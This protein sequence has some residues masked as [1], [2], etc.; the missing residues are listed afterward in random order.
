MADPSELWEWVDA[1]GVAFAFTEA[2]GLIAGQGSNFWMPQTRRTEARIPGRV[3]SYVLDRTYRE[4]TAA[5]SVVVKSSSA[6]TMEAALAAWSSR[7]N[8]LRGAGYLRHT[9][10]DGITKRLLYCEYDDGLGVQQGQGIWRKGVQQA[11]LQF[12]A[13]DPFWYDESLTTVTFTSGTA[14]AAFFPIPNATTGSFI[15]LTASEVFASTTVDNEGD[16]PVFPVWTIAGPASSIALRNT[17][18]GKSIAFSGLSLTAGQTLT[19]DT[20]PGSTE[21]TVGGSSVASYLTDASE[22]WPLELGD[23]VVSVELAGTLAGT[24][25]ASLSYRLPHLTP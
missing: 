6:S 17:T 5:L 22:L 1:D 8:V 11:V 9:R 19:V 10:V 13:A 7:V 23:N 24:T 14:L 15:T 2:N 18:T 4:R 16:A 21:I 3:G 25:A 20:R 12:Y